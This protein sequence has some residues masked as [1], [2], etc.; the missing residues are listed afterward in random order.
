MKAICLQDDGNKQKN[1][2]I[3]GMCIGFGV[4]LAIGLLI[5]L[6]CKC[7]CQFQDNKLLPSPKKM[8][9]PTRSKPKPL[10]Y[11]V[12]MN[13]VEGVNYNRARSSASTAMPNSRNEFR[14]DVFEDDWTNGPV[15]GV[16]PYHQPSRSLNDSVSPTS[17]KS[18]EYLHF[19]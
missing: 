5:C 1:S 19:M 9:L 10:Q 15:I 16:E 14:D 3:V 18:E 8:K 7:C 4:F 2:M 17:D 12:Y 11:E 13:Q 6:M